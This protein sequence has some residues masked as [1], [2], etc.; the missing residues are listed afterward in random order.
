MRDVERAR[1]LLGGQELG[2]HG[3]EL[4]LGKQRR[5]RDCVRARH[6]L[7]K[8]AVGRRLSVSHIHMVSPL[9]STHAL[10]SYRR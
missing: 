10:G 1:M 5:G 3:H 2:D 4:R 8:A 7:H 6:A 9:F